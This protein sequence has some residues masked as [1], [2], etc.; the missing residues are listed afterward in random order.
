MEAGVACER[1]LGRQ[2]G[3][4]RAG[5]SSEHA[6]YLRR[7]AVGDSEHV[8]A[9]GRGS[10]RVPGGRHGERQKGREIVLQHWKGM[11]QRRRKCGAKI[12]TRVASF[13]S[14][15]KWSRAAGGW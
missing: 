10:C 7:T 3:K 12:V 1:K 5:E 15:R 8:D 14:A 11:D 4:G 13:A 9:P 6:M 2:R